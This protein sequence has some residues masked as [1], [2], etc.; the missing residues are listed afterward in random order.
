[1]TRLIIDGRPIE[2]PTGTKV[3]EAAERLGIIIPRFCY[4]RGLGPLGACRLCAV[5]FL[6]GPVQGVQMSCMT[7]AMDGMVVSTTDEEAVEFRRQVIEWLMMHHPHDCPV[8]D[9]GGHCLLQDETISGGH[10][11]RRFLGPKRTFPDQDLGPFIQHEMNRCI[12]CW[13]CRR[14]Y[15]EF[16]GYRDYGALHIANRTWFGRLAA[17]PLENPF[18]GNIIDLCPTGVLTDKPSRYRGR[19]WDYERGASLCIHCS[20]GCS[21]VASARYREVVRLEAGYSEKVN[22]WFICDRG[23]W[24]FAY[25][26]LPER[27]RTALVDGREVTLDEGVREAAARLSQSHA[28]PGAGSVACLGSTRAGNEALTAL[29]DLSRRQGWGT[30]ACFPHAALARATARAVARLDERVAVSLR[31]IEEA[32]F[33]LALG[34]DPVNEAPLLALSV[35]QAARRGAAVV[36]IDPRAVSLPCATL[37]LAV[38]PGNLERCLAILCREAVAAGSLVNPAARSFRASLDAVASFGAG[39]DRMITEAAGLLARSARPVVVCGTG[40]VRETTPDLAADVAFLLRETGKKA[41]LFYLLPGPNAFGAILAGCGES[42]DT[43]VGEIERGGIAALLAV[44]SDPFFSFSDRTRLERALD[45]LDLLVVLDYL[46]TPLAQRAHVVL[47]TASLFEAAATFINQEGRSRH[48]APVHAG[49]L[50]VL[51]D[52]GGGHPPRVF[53]SRP[54]GSDPAPAWQLLGRIAAALAPSLP[55]RDA[56]EDTAA[57]PAGLGTDP[58]G[59]RVIPGQGPAAMFETPFTPGTESAGRDLEL[60]VV[61][62][63]FGTEELSSY[64]PVTARAGQPPAACLHPSE[65]AELGLSPG[66][67]ISLGLDGGSLEV[68]L[69]VREEMARGVV[70]IPRRPELSWQKINSFPARL[71][72]ERIRPVSPPPGESGGGK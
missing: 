27:P 72:R 21:L 52:G 54:P 28:R 29:G 26:G 36:V 63:T 48:A 64:S 25:S 2:V 35:R 32:D 14:F 16:A 59:A 12:H 49:G 13:R 15:Q 20:L 65:A 55:E 19:R 47:P 37:R 71:S 62:R 56:V 43:L 10:G 38:A 44:E 40:I 7:D 66:G 23:R 18:S 58:D 45:R 53:R 3:I 61:D 9:E 11:R 31:E 57:A 69:E 70:V 8:C 30:P 39:L 60:L 33:I 34:A 24:G 46:P 41:G 51:L 42:L 22:G 4:H 1:M 67:L 6:E 68:V 50:P 5:S 17:G